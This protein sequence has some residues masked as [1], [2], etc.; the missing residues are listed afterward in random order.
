MK[1]KGRR[2][3]RTIEQ[4]ENSGVDSKQYKKDGIA[5]ILFGV[6]DI[7][8][9]YY[10]QLFWRDDTVIIL[11][12]VV[13]LLLL[14]F[15]ITYLAGFFPKGK[16]RDG[17]ISIW[18]IIAIISVFS[19][20][21]TLKNDQYSPFF[22]GLV[23]L[24]IMLLMG[25]PAVFFGHIVKLGVW[26][27]WVP[28]AVGI[29]I[30]VGSVLFKDYQVSDSVF[31]IPYTLALIS[32]GFVIIRGPKHKR[33]P[34]RAIWAIAIVL[35]LISATGVG[36]YGISRTWQGDRASREI[37]VAMDTTLPNSVTRANMQYTKN[38]DSN[39]LYIS[40]Y[41][42]EEDVRQWVLE[43]VKG[44]KTDIDDFYTKDGLMATDSDMSKAI[45]NHG[46]DS[47]ADIFSLAFK[48][49]ARLMRQLTFLEDVNDY[50]DICGITSPRE[51]PYVIWI[52]E[53]DGDSMYVQ[54]LSQ[55]E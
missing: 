17:L 7:A 32:A 39:M 50:A 38:L 13:K 42:S 4:T 16:L 43:G 21:D 53:V 47:V 12:A 31:R 5:W 52:S 27:I 14:F 24:K 19:D 26:E 48:W 44:F 2:K 15:M 10:G 3:M 30:R 37:S 1:G 35:G 46:T 20:Y 34:M 8:M 54:I 33:T 40:F 11:V 41:A 18:A 25:I 9:Y 55:R 49:D 36:V 29:L 22:I 51:T 6:L 45:M 28:I 23:L